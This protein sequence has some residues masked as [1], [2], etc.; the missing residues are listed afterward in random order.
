M[1]KHKFIRVTVG[2]RLSDDKF[3][4][5]NAEI[6]EEVE[7]ESGDDVKDVRHALQRRVLKETKALLMDTVEATKAGVS[8]ISKK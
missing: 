7:I 8:K 1:A 4:S 2:R 3:G 6:T 5:F